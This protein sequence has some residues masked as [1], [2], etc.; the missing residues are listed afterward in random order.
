[1]AN[2]PDLKIDVV[3]PHRC[4]LGEGPVWD[5]KN[6]MICWIDIV[7][8]EIHEYSPV[9]VRHRTIR[10]DQMIGAITICDDGNF[11][12]ALKNGFGFINRENGAGTMTANPET[13]LPGNRFNDGKCDPAGRFWAGTMS[14]TDE[15]EKGSLYIFNNDHSVIKKIT[16]VSISNGLAWSMDHRTF[17][18][19]DTPTRTVVSYNYDVKSGEI[20]DKKIIIKIAEEDGYPDGMTI[21]NEGMLWVAHWDGWQVSRWNP[22]TGE[23]LSTIRL[24]VARVTCC[25]FGGENFEDLYITSA[26]R[27]L[28]EKELEEQPLAGSLFVI[29]NIGHKGLPPFK[30][31]N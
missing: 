27:G 20:S 16:P 2:S 26:M 11:I 30:F 13:H 4:L 31:K 10:I 22:G 21:D 7:N 12:A 8:G 6:Q 1:M 24:P 29:K 17:Y 19:I 9:E 25:T 28:T 23:K 3:L 18:Y 5:E 15:P 14:H